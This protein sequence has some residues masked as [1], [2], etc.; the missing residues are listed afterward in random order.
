[1]PKTQKFLDIDGLIYLWSKIKMEDYPNNETLVAVINAI[2]ETKVDREELEKLLAQEIPSIESLSETDLLEIMG[3]P[4]GL[5]VNP[6]GQVL[7]EMSAEDVRNI[8]KI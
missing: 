6:S 7:H 3:M 8:I 1:M 5:P 2:D 4:G